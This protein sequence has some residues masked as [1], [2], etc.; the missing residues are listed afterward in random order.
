MDNDFRQISVS[1][2]LAKV[3]EIIQ[4]QLYKGDLKIKDNQHAFTLGRSIVSAL[5]SISQ[6]W[7]NKTENSRD[8]R[9]V[10]T[11]YLSTFAK[12]LIWWTTDY[13]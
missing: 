6:N 2:Q 1:Q 9:M 12:H 4:L 11:F 8:G 10:S 3:L 7:F 13:F 5:A